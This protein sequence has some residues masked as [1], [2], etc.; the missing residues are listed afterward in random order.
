VEAS[1]IRNAVKPLMAICRRAVDDSDLATNPALGLR[2]PA[3]NARR[4]RIAG[5]AEA[6]T[7]LTALDRSDDRAT[8]ACAFYAGLR[9]GELRGLRWSD[10]DETAG[11]VRVERAVD[12]SGVLIEP[13][14]RA[15]RRTVPLLRQLRA[16]LALHR[17]ET[18]APDDAYVFGNRHGNPFTPNAVRV[19]SGRVWAAAG[20]APIGF[21]EAR[22]AFASYLIAAGANAKEIT[23][24]M[25]HS[26]V[27]VT[28]DRYGH[29]M[30]R[31]E[32]ETIRRVEAFLDASST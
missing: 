5:P 29:L 32:A 1:T 4:E 3:A 7:L 25:G 12:Q 8:W 9:L 17:L 21:H 14:S 27:T 16:E 31:S 23:V 24:W 28:F 10:V 20:L 19:R 22:H 18:Q 11:V 15:G 13:K 2:L 30:A 26:S 6:A